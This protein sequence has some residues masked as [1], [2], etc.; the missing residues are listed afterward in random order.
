MGGMLY[1]CAEVCSVWEAIP[2]LG[3]LAKSLTTTSINV[4]IGLSPVIGLDWTIDQACQLGNSYTLED[5]L[6]YSLLIQQ[7]SSRISHLMSGNQGSST[8]LPLESESSIVLTI[9]EGDLAD[10]ENHLN[11]RLQGIISSLL[12]VPP[13]FMWS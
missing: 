6:R 3:R 9:L 2:L 8:G 5:N 11:G 13:R 12:T 4:A 1:R 7:L 10:L